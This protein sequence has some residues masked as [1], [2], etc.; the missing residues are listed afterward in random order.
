MEVARL[1]KANRLRKLDRHCRAF[2]KGAN[3]N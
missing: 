2:T 1:V 3:E